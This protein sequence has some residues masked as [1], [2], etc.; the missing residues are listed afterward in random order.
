MVLSSNDACI[1]AR[2]NEAKALGIPM[3]APLYEYEKLLKKN[4]AF[5]M[6]ANFALYGDMSSRVMQ[7]LSEYSTDFEIY[8]IDEA[9]LF[10]PEFLNKSNNELFYISYAGHMR[11]KVKQRTG[12]PISIGIGSTKTLAKVANN[13]A[14]KSKSGVVDIS[15]HPNIDS[16]LQN[17]KVED[18]WGI[19]RRYSKKL[20][21]NN[22]LNAKDLKYKDDQWIKKN[23]TICGLKTVYELRGISCLEL[24][25]TNE[26]K[27]SITVSRLF[28]RNVTQI[29]ELKEAIASYVITA[30]QKAR[31]QSSIVS[32]ITLFLMYTNYHD[33]QRYFIS[34]SY[35][36]AISTSYTPDLINGAINCLM[37]IFKP[38]LIYKK[39]GVILNDLYSADFLQM[40]TYCALPN[41]E[42]QSRIIKTIDEINKKNRKNLVTYAAA[43]IGQSWKMKQ[44]K[45][46]QCFTTSWHEIL[47]IKI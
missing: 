30:A 43:G 19:G 37:K 22:I 38:G 40:N 14:K 6:S 9:F 16:I 42:K 8:S 11:N 21:S 4:N 36:F 29:E 34:S 15:N 1:I 18:I 12:I 10:I 20:I 41:V 47:T 28:G 39:A 7:V 2:S 25:E 35:S 33:S 26:A 17:F 31:D 23:L 27:K 24:N 13:L 46:S 5:I 32:S 45:K 3:G 44:L